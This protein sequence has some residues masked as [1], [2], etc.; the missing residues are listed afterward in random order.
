MHFSPLIFS[1]FPLLSGPSPT[2]GEL[3]LGDKQKS[4][5]KP[6]YVLDLEGVHAIYTCMGQGSSYLLID[7]ESDTPEAEAMREI[8]KEGR[9][10]IHDPVEPPPMAAGTK[11]PLKEASPSARGRGRGRM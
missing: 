4:S 3:G 5:T 9:L 1:R 10:D 7:D 6:Q 11:R 8:L 2:S